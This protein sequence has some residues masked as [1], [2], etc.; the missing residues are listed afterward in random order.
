MFR[1]KVLRREFS[2]GGGGQRKHVCFYASYNT[3]TSRE[4]IKT[5]HTDLN[6]TKRKQKYKSAKMHNICLRISD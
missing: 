1:A 5:N 2:D 4:K 3:K 6:K